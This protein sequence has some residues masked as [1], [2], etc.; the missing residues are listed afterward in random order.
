VKI[1]GS[2]WA[3]IF[4]W[5]ISELG[6]IYFLTI[7]GCVFVSLNGKSDSIFQLVYLVDILLLPFTFL[8]IFLQWRVIKYWC[9]LCILIIIIIWIK[10]YFLSINIEFNFI[11]IKLAEG[12]PVALF[13]T[14][15]LAIWNNIRDKYFASYEVL[16]MKK[17]LTWFKTNSEV[18]DALIK[19]QP[20]EV[21]LLD[22]SNE[23]FVGNP[24]AQ[25][26]LTIFT[27]FTCSTCKVV[28]SEIISML[29][30]F[31]NLKVVLKFPVTQDGFVSKHLFSIFLSNGEK[32]LIRAFT[33]KTEFEDVNKWK[34]KF[35]VK[36]IVKD[37]ILDK[38]VD[39]QKFWIR[40]NNFN[41]T[42]TFILNGQVLPEMYS[43]VELKIQLKRILS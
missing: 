2:K 14:L 15:F 11:Q 31:N 41:R 33:E 18:F 7:L 6:L 29:S 13:F 32:D 17:K 9:P 28:N 21:A 4:D 37:I 22:F 23:L 5:R 38:F 10:L 8:S 25:N 27:S 12:L 19:V 39:E 42:P 24:K 26:V 16:S 3:K 35:P 1:L 20:K 40:S 34:E 43:F 30:M 36:N